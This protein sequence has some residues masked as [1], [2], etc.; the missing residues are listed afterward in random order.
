[1]RVAIRLLWRLRAWLGPSA[2]AVVGLGLLLAACTLAAAEPVRRDAPGYFIEF[3]A[4][5]SV[6]FGHTFIVYGRVDASG[7]TVE[8]RHAGFIPGDDFMMALIYPVRGT[9]GP[10]PAD[11]A[12]P[13]TAVYRRRLSAVE[14][15]RVVDKVQLL[16]ATQH[17][18]HFFFF[19]CNDFAIEIA[20]TLYLHRLPSLVA[21]K[22]WVDGLRI[23]NGD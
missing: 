21:P 10:D 13:S 22:L 12:L 23:L 19:N 3:R 18:W 16:R 14:Y 9:V 20:E 11:W 15:R 1:M 17:E 7:R 6:Y 8:R 4:R 2:G 5:P